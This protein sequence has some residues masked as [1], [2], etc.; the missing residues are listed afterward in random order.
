MALGWC[1]SFFW[2]YFF[3][4]TGETWGY[5]VIDGTMASYFWRRSNRV[6][7]ALPLFYVHVCFVG[8]N[9]VATLA[10]T[11]DWW[12]AFVLN[13][14]FEAELVYILGC[15]AYRMRKLRK[16]KKGAPLERPDAILKIVF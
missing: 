11:N 9:L 13:R 8:A 12:L 3:Y 6:L 4:G 7:F 1:A 5:A 10:R 14:L 2:F 15:S 16:K